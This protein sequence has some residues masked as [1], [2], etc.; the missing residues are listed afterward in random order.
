MKNAI[1]FIVLFALS[2]C[3][4][5]SYYSSPNANHFKDLGE[6]DTVYIYTKTSSV[7]VED[8]PTEKNELFWRYTKSL[9]KDFS[10]TTT[11]VNKTLF[12]S[13]TLS[14]IP[15]KFGSELKLNLA[16]QV[17]VAVLN[18]SGKTLIH[19]SGVVAVQSGSGSISYFLA[20]N[21]FKA[22][23]FSG[24]ISVKLDDVFDHSGFIRSESGFISVYTGNLNHSLSLDR[25]ELYNEQL[26]QKRRP[27]DFKNVKPPYIFIEC[28]I[29]SLSIESAGTILW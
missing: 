22:E 29:K 14:K 27:L 26:I 10:I 18:D 28:A 13:D 15:S 3:T 17:V 21:H 12:I 4:A 24:N 25:R 2:A 8:N 7:I 16:P 1:Y 23:S 19:H 9:K 6:I 20:R 11:L 5:A